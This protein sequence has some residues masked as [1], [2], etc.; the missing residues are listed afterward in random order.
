[1]PTPTLA[2]S[3]R[4]ITAPSFAWFGAAAWRHANACVPASSTTTSKRTS[5]QAETT[6][7]QP[8]ECRSRSGSRVGSRPSSMPSLRLVAS[9]QVGRGRLCGS[10]PV[11]WLPCLHIAVKAG[12]IV[13]QTLP[14]QHP[15][16]LDP[17]KLAP[18]IHVEKVPRSA[19]MK[20]GLFGGARARGGPAG[21]SH[22]YHDF[23]N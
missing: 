13:R 9:Q 2:G 23:V 1:M 14:E 12:T 10:R 7:R 17:H 4:G 6:T 5:A 21:D 20:F 11:A 19:R 15:V 18:Y 3:C 8:P 22:A 16:F